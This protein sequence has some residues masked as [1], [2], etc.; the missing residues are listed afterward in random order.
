[1]SAGTGKVRLAKNIAVKQRRMPPQ[2]A[3]VSCRDVFDKRQLN[4]LVR[5]PDGEVALDVIGKMSGRG[6]YLCNSLVCWTKALKTKRLE[7]ALNCQISAETLALVKEKAESLKKE[8]VAAAV[9]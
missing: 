8:A 7:K 2:R 4:R 6:A 1:M 3:C 9:V 5:K